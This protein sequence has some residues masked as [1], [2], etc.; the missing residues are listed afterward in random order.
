MIQQG[1]PA[2]GQF[3]IGRRSA[4]RAVESGFELCL[5]VSEA[6][7]P[8][9]VILHCSQHVFACR[10]VEIGSGSGYVSCSLA[11]LLQQ[12]NISASCIATDISL[13][14][15]TATKETLAAHQVCQTADNIAVKA[16]KFRTFC[17]F[18]AR[19]TSCS[20]ICHYWYWVVLLQPCFWS[21]H[22]AEL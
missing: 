6:S 14:A 19:C 12:C 10:C 7:R 16:K 13:H 8:A 5:P 17:I 11:L 15:V 18:T 3:R 21:S 9:Y 1:S 4:A 22:N 2:T 20:H